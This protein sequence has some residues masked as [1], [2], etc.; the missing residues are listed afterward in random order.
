[1]GYT[2]DFNGKLSVT[3]AASEELVNYINTFSSTR[4]MGRDVD[5]LHRLYKGKH[6]FEGDYGVNGEYFAKE[7]GNFGQGNCTSIQNYNGS[8]TTQP[9]L[10]CQWVLDESGTELEWDEGEKFYS[11]IEWLEYLI[12]NFFEPK[13]HKLNGEIQWWGEEREDVGTIFVKDNKVQTEPFDKEE[14]PKKVDKSLPITHKVSGTPINKESFVE[15]VNTLLDGAKDVLSRN[16]SNPIVSQFYAELDSIAKVI[17]KS[18][19]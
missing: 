3:P 15:G 19:K 9:G 13:G 16:A 17:T 4:R 11:Y 8:P 18:L 2:T 1:M 7:D 12:K 14:E 6:G 5:T 10:W